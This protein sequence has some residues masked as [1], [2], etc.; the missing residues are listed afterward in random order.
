MKIWGRKGEVRAR[1]A[2]GLLAPKVT[3]NV[4]DG[5]NDFLCRRK[6]PYRRF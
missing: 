2:S 1:G 4:I 3:E 6:K 5:M